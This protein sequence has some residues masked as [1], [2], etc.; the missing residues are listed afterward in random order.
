VEVAVWFGMAKPPEDPTSRPSPEPRAERS[1]AQDGEA[2]AE[3]SAPPATE[4]R[5]EVPSR[6]PDRLRLIVVPDGPVAAWK[7]LR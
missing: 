2:A 7:E 5:R 6:R 4:P 1:L 3:A